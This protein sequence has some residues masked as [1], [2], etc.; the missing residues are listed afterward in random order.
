MF[1]QLLNSQLGPIID[2]LLEIEEH[3]EDLNRRADSFIR[4]GTCESVDPGAGRC[5]VTHG[6][7]KTP[8]I[9][10][11]NPSAGEQSETRHP[12]KG[13][14]CVLLNYGGGDSSAQSVALFGLSTDA[15]PLTSATAELTRRLYKD[16]T[17][18]SYDHAAHV[19]AWKSGPV[20]LS[21]SREGVELKVGEARIA[22]KPDSVE[23]ML[24]LT[25]L[26]IDE[27]GVHFSGPLIDH[28]GKIMSTA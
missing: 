24:G 2:R 10:Y 22:L 5:V 19:L 28:Q 15:F 3:L 11:F 26:L 14:Q 20:A 4:I 7:L 23:L 21:A 6:D 17:E 1:S 8:Q 13:E 12:S 27:E 9:K 25:G 18:S 16:G